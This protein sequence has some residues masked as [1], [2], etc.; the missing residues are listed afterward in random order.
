MIDAGLLK[1]LIQDIES[2]KSER[3]TS[4]NNFDKFGEAICAFCNDLPNN[5]QP[6]YLIIGVTD[7]GRI[8]GVNVSDELL[9]NIAALRTDGNIQP[10][11]TMNVS[12]VTLNGKDIVVVEVQPSLLPPVKYKGKIYVR[13]GPRKS[14]ANEGDE[15]IL[16]EKRASNIMT[17]DAMPCIGK[18][19]DDLDISLFLSS[20]LPKAIPME[21]LMTDKRDVKFQLASLGFYDLRFDCP[22]HAGLIMFEKTVSP[23]RASSYIQY[24][25]FKGSNRTGKVLSEY[26][27]VG[28]LMQILPK[29]D[30]FVD[31]TIT[32]RRP[33]PVSA[34]REEMVMD[35]PYWSIRE[36]LMNAICHRDYECNTPIQFYHYDD[37]IEIT[38]PG[39]LYGKVRPENFPQV[40]DYRNETIAE[41]MKVLG[42][43]NRFSRGI[44][45]V[46][47]ELKDNANPEPRFDLNLLTAFRVTVDISTRPADLERVGVKL[48]SNN[49]S[50]EHGSIEPKNNQIEPQNVQK[51]VQN[52]QIEPSNG[53]MNNGT[54]NPTDD[55]I[56][57][58]NGQINDKI[59]QE[60][61]PLDK[62]LAENE[63][64][65]DQINKP[66]AENEPLDDRKDEP[67]AENEPL[68]NRIIAL[69]KHNPKLSLNDL[70]QITSMSLSTIKRTIKTLVNSGRLA[71]KGGKR[72]G[73]WEILKDN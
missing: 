2:D 56:N 59:V 6:G 11:P 69:F 21:M 23:Y 31:A 53:Q 3:T 35:Y 42:Y 52:G 46:Y 67:L 64:L 51:D 72:F 4:T 44:L 49:V 50:N 24:V 40:N 5:Q 13:I 54:L 41:A 16:F 22:T 62:P 68:E 12:K 61:K 19:M 58:E 32:N 60:D 39:G 9:R 14:V 71:R 38:N 8:E 26:R 37:H 17:F 36:L 34:I 45:T 55:Q 20:Y 7:K 1:M 70:A 57:S 30:T 15:R 27:F 73:Y 29:I 66:L 47:N 33:I 25:R 48:F 10:Q 18:T 28:N 65:D 43:V 63:P